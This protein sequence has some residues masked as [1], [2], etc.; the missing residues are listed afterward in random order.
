MIGSAN[1]TRAALLHRVPG[2]NVELVVLQDVSASDLKRALP[3]AT[4]LPPEG[5]D[6]E[7]RGDPSDEDNEAQAGAERYVLEATYRATAARLSLVFVPGAP[8][9]EIRYGDALLDGVRADTT[10]SSPLEL[11]APRYV[12]VD[13]GQLAGMVPFVIV[14]QEA[15]APRGNAMVVGLETFFEILAGNREPPTPA[16]GDPRTGA[17]AAIGDVEVVGARG[18]I[19]WRRYLAA[20]AGIGRELERERL[21]IR[22][23]RFTIE[24]PTRLRGL[25]DR[26]HQ[27]RDDR[28]FTGADLLYAL[29]ELEHELRRVLALESPDETRDLLA[30]AATEI[31][32]DRT[33]LMALVA[34]DVREQLRILNAMDLGWRAIELV[35]DHG[36]A[37]ET[38]DRA[39]IADQLATAS[40]LRERLDDYGG[41]ILGDEVGAGKTYVTFALLAEALAKDPRKGAVIFV[42]S[43]LLKAKWCNQLQDYLR[44]A[45][46]NRTL[47][48]RFIER[49]T[50]IDRSLRDDGSFDSSHWGRRPRGTPL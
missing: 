22:G 43:G 37:D 8:Q 6:F 34:P 23:L 32:N 20:V 31:A 2:A 38:I 14:D 30:A 40:A 36:A 15:L 10:W 26:L 42:P 50:P 16:D 47:A 28:R 17:S 21:N 1:L 35:V 13:D 11:A 48:E 27:A 46:R 18:A 4:R 5:V 29:Y 19:P 33:K 25:I 24:N 7:D 12:T 9:L 45:M 41:V 3:Q 49:I 44:A 39:V